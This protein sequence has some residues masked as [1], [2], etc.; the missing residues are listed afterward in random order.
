MDARVANSTVAFITGF[1]VVADASILARV[2]QTFI[3]VC[4]AEL[5]SIANRA[6]ADFTAINLASAAILTRCDIANRCISS[7]VHHQ[8]DNGAIF[9]EVRTPDPLSVAGEGRK[10]NERATRND[11]VGTQLMSSRPA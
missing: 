10:G 8:V 11:T 3:K 1:G 5:S 6:V 7:A 9:T 4:L 2:T